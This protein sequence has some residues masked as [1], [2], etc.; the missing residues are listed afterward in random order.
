[1]RKALKV[2][3]MVMGLVVLRKLWSF[4]TTRFRI[5]TAGL[6][7]SRQAGHAFVGAHLGATKPCN[8]PGRAQMRSYKKRWRDGSKRDVISATRYAASRPATST[9]AQARTHA[10][11]QT[12]CRG[13]RRATGR[14]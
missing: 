14:G 11:T 6:V 7:H 12:A 9:H 4:C 1:M 10:S 5:P 3:G 8:E 2:C 13:R